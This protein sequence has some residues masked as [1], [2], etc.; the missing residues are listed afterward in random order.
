MLDIEWGFVQ[1]HLIRF[2]NLYFFMALLCVHKILYCMAFR[3]GFDD[4]FN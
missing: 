1:I 3:Y 2:S 4:G